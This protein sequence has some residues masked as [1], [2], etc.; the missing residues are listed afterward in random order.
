MTAV[1]SPYCRIASPA[2]PAGATLTSCST[3][4]I[5]FQPGTSASTKARPLILSALSNTPNNDSTGIS[6]AALILMRLSAISLSNR[7]LIFS[8]WLT[9]STSDWIGI[10][11]GKFSRTIPVGCDG[12]AAAGSCAGPTRR[13][14]AP[15]TS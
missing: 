3:L 14:A 13:A 7:M 8:R 15:M 2:S 11:C 6:L 4:T 5:F 12:A 10:S 1:A 9:N